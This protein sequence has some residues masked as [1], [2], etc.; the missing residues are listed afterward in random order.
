MTSS[1]NIPVRMP[2]DLYQEIIKNKPAELKVST[3][4]LLLLRKGLNAGGEV[5]PSPVDISIKSVDNAPSGTLIALLQERI[6]GLEQQL[7]A[8]QDVVDNAQSIREESNK[9]LST[10]DTTVELAVQ[11]AVDNCLQFVDTRIQ[12]VVNKEMSEILGETV[13]WES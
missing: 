2:E 1:R 10:I 7:E 9:A 12:E 4:L 11:K 6:A 13:A 3:Y 5:I 8:V